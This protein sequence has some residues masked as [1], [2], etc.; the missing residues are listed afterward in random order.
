MNTNTII[1]IVQQIQYAVSQLYSLPAAALVGLTC[2]VVGY[3]LKRWKTFPNEAI[4]T[5]IVLWGA[6]FCV[7]LAAPTPQGVTL[8]AW[9]VKNALVGVV[10]GFAAWGLHYYLLSRLE[11]KFP[12]LKSLLSGADGAP[13]TN[14]PPTPK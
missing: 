2:I 5:V 11:D 3:L 14:I 8:G 12:W 6:F 4:P 9:R 1:L 10:V 7:M 13:S